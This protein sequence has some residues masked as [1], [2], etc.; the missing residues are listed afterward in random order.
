MK[1]LDLTG[2]LVFI[3]FGLFRNARLVAPTY[4][5][6]GTNT[7]TRGG[8]TLYTLG[9]FVFWGSKFVF[10]FLYCRRYNKRS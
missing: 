8:S 4:T 7:I 1:F 3:G 6:R 10:P 2:I 5:S 9:A